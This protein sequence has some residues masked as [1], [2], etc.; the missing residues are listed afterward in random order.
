[1]DN[2]NLAEETMEMATESK[3][4]SGLGLLMIGALSIAAYECVLR[5]GKWAIK[6]I[7]SKKD[8]KQV[9]AGNQETSEEQGFTEVNPE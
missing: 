6:K 1:M 7:K 8:Q 3:G 9:D 4:F 5:T 2:T